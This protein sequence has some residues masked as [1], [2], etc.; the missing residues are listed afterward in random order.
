MFHVTT[1]SESLNDQR[2]QRIPGSTEHQLQEMWVFDE[3]GSRVDPNAGW[4]MLDLVELAAV[5]GSFKDFR[6]EQYND[7]NIIYIYLL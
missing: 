5:S 4:N 1:N 2:I 3:V 6:G 7:Y